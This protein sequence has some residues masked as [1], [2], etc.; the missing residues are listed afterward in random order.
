MLQDVNQK[1]NTSGSEFFRKCS[2]AKH[3]MKKYFWKNRTAFLY[4]N[5]SP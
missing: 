2:V 4:Q 1:S 3:N 5:Q